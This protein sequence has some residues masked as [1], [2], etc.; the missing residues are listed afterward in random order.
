MSQFRDE[1]REIAMM[2]VSQ[3][4]PRPFG[5]LIG[6]LPGIAELEILGES[7]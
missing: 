3:P 1:I 7:S 2:F 4:Y 6:A 5:F